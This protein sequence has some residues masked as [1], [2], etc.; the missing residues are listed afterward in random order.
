[1]VET[2]TTHHRP[3]PLTPP[4]NLAEARDLTA[5]RQ[6]VARNRTNQ[7][8]VTRAAARLTAGCAA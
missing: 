3:T 5:Y 7:A 6:Q 4:M 1:M 8:A 2:T